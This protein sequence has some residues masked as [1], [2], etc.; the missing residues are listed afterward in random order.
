MT[1]RDHVPLEYATPGSSEP[2]EPSTPEAPNRF[3]FIVL[4]ITGNAWLLI[5]LALFVGQTHER[6]SPTRYSAFGVG[7]WFS[8]GEYRTMVLVCAAMGVAML[9]VGWRRGRGA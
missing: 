9:V 2:R 8:A 1:E 3:K 6:S 7:G 4:W 5:A